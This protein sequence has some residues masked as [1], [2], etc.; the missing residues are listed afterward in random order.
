TYLN[1]I[2]A[3]GN[4]LHAVG[5]YNTLLQSLDGGTTWTLQYG[6]QPAITMFNA[7]FFPNATKGWAVG[8][9]TFDGGC[10]EYTNNGGTTWGRQL[11]QQ[12][13]ILD[14][15]DFYTTPSG[16]DSLGWV[17]G[18]GLPPAASSPI[19]FIYSTT[20][21]G[22]TWTR[23]ATGVPTSA[24]AYMIAVNFANNATGWSLGYDPTIS[25]NFVLNSTN[26]GST[27]S[28]QTASF[29]ANEHAY[30]L[31]STSLTK[32]FLGGDS[33]GFATV[34]ESVNGG[35]SWS[36]TT[37]TG[38]EGTV[39]KVTFP[40]SSIG[41]AAGLEDSSGM[42]KPF[43]LKT[44]NGGLSWKKLYNTIVMSSNGDYSEVTSV[45]AYDANHVY[46]CGGNN[47]GWV[48]ASS[49]GGA[50]WQVKSYNA[51]TNNGTAFNP[52]IY[53]ASFT[54]VNNGWAVG[55]TDNY[56]TVPSNNFNPI[57]L[58][59]TN[60]GTNWNPF[61][62]P[63]TTD[64][65]LY[66]GVS[67]TSLS[68]VWICYPDYSQENSFVYHST[69]GGTTWNSTA[70]GTFMYANDIRFSSDSIG[71]V[72][73][74]RGDGS[75][76]YY[77]TD[78]GATWNP[79][80]F[81]YDG[82][83]SNITRI[84]SFYGLDAWAVGDDES[85]YAIFN[86]NDG[87]QTWNVTQ[88]N[89]F[90]NS[91]V[92][93]YIPNGISFTPS[94]QYGWV[95]GTEDSNNVYSSFIAYNSDYGNSEAWTE[96]SDNV[97]IPNSINP[98][99]PFV[100]ANSSQFDNVEDVLAVSGLAAAAL[101]R[102][103][104]NSPFAGNRIIVTTNGGNTWYNID[105]SYVGTEYYRIAG[106]LTNRIDGW[107]V[108]GTGQIRH[109]YVNVPL[110]STSN[111]SLFRGRIISWT[112]TDS[113]TETIHICNPGTAPLN[114]LDWG[115][116]SRDNAYQ[117]YTILYMPR[118]LAPG[119]C[120][121]IVVQFKPDEFA[122]RPADLGLLT[123]A[124]DTPVFFFQLVGTGGLS[125]VQSYPSS[126]FGNNIV[127]ANGGSE[128]DTVWV[129]NDG[130]RGV[131]AEIKVGDPVLDNHDSCYSIV[132][133]ITNR[134]LP[135]DCDYFLVKFQPTSGGP[136]SGTLTFTTNTR[137]FPTFTVVLGGVGGIRTIASNVG[138]QSFTDTVDCTTTSTNCFTISNSGT[139]PMHINSDTI[140]GGLP[141]DYKVSGT[142][143]ATLAAGAKDTICVTYAPTRE[144][145]DSALLILSSDAFNA[146]KDT[147][148]L[149]GVGLAAQLS[150]STKQI[151]RTQL[152]LNQTFDTSVVIY[153]TGNTPAFVFPNLS[154]LTGWQ[155]ILPFTQ[156]FSD[157]TV[158]NIRNNGPSRSV[159]DTL[160]V[161][162]TWGNAGANGLQ[163]CGASHLD[164]I[165]FIEQFGIP[166]S[167]KEQSQVASS[168]GL[169]QNY[170]NPFNPVT[171]IEYSIPQRANV[172]L[173][174]YN[175]LG[176]AVQTLVHQTQES[177]V[178]NATFDASNL[179]NGNYYYE[180]RAGSFMKRMMMTLTK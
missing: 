41:Y 109:G 30:S 102:Q 150:Y 51:A 69:N 46:L 23:Q 36:N 127:P 32:V 21:G 55:V 28:D 7:T 73:G 105:S 110:F 146:P 50:T 177:G 140:V 156:T 17:V 9:S 165:E 62:K 11:I 92:V 107:A 179:P 167:V 70:V 139:L 131:Y 45:Y 74:E 116:D 75:A 175:M 113:V 31:T 86:T 125:E 119:A 81:D 43:V 48:A 67:A 29:P 91:E 163:G 49:D 15:V 172:T 66:T 173:T 57:L 170:P 6:D 138:E 35:N 68:N 16:N 19:P 136:K 149:N 27:W 65:I 14:G 122:Y 47:G 178:Y 101:T 95:T 72:V 78:G 180:L 111:D 38:I 134:I 118:S 93:T 141:S 103:D 108:G 164:T 79:S 61:P 147:L 123:N 115:L 161:V 120:D 54:D 33:A 104:H 144:G 5:Q 126:L 129:C 124:I 142:I 12:A 53:S 171:N 162:L 128:I 121:S 96:Q 40:N 151:V 132:K 98:V 44:T 71:I 169:L 148:M 90:G 85:G 88:T 59:T 4:T 24:N 22:N 2:T 37:F 63:S 64:N 8:N 158:L 154:S 39:D 42:W 99:P 56:L 3:T 137:A 157:S 152:P 60:G 87:G 133:S 84:G 26:S 82:S 155:L 106:K 77:T 97:L 130:S 80:R 153:N 10:V 83:I 25:S 112:P 13:T 159:T 114:I 176:E 20:D 52:F 135:G 168:F 76:A 94:G 18:A 100:Q 143:P 160:D 174:V 34:Y 117:D 89:I 166:L 1:D 58:R 145:P